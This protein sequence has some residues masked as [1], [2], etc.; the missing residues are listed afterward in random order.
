MTAASLVSKLPVDEEWITVPARVG[1]ARV[2]LIRPPG[3]TG[4]L[5][6]IVHTAAHLSVRR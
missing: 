3:A 4:T 5:P 2:R 6:V 1:D